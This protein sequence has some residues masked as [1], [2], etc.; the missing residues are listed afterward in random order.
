MHH[1]TD[2]RHLVDWVDCAPAHAGHG[3][4]RDRDET[5]LA[6]G[7][8]DRHRRRRRLLR[9][10]LAHPTRGSGSIGARSRNCLSPSRALDCGSLWVWPCCNACKEVAGDVR[11][12]QRNP[13]AGG[14]ENLDR[15]VDRQRRHPCQALGATLMSTL[16]LRRLGRRDRPAIFDEHF[17]PSGGQR[18]RAD[19]FR[20]IRRSGGVSVF[21]ALKPHALPD[22]KLCLHQ[23]ARAV[24]VDFT[25]D[26]LEL[27]AGEE[28][29]ENRYTVF[30]NTSSPGPATSI[31]Q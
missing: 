14:A 29:V 9:S 20:I 6:H 5:S 13:I 15:P 30:V 10:R 27:L 28:S 19:D 11:Q 2:G 3:A 25:L 23:E 7:A 24:V 12:R 4:A 16:R 21:K 31:I 22:A 26:T 17:P 18:T 8:L 1:N